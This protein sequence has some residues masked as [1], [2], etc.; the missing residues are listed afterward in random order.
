VAQM[1]AKAKGLAATAV[2]AFFMTGCGGGGGGDAAV[3]GVPSSA[4][5]AGP[6][7]SAT[8]TTGAPT[9][10]ATSNSPLPSAATF[11]Q[12]LVGGPISG[13]AGPAISRLSDGRS[14]VVWV[15]GADRT[16]IA[17]L[18]D[19]AGGLSGPTF[20][21]PI[22][23]PIGST[24]RGVMAA[25]AV[26]GGFVLARE[27][28]DPTPCCA[29]S[30]TG[31]TGRIVFERYASDGT[32]L[33][34]REVANRTSLRIGSLQMNSDGTYTLGYRFSL[35]GLSPIQGFAARLTADGVNLYG[36]TA[37]PTFGLGVEAI[38]AAGL[39]DGSVGVV[40][41]QT[42]GSSYGSTVI[43]AHQVV[44][45]RLDPSG[46][47]IGT[48]LALSPPGSAKQVAATALPNDQIA[49]AWGSDDTTTG[50]GHS[51]AAVIT[52]D[53][54]VAGPVTTMDSAAP[55][56]GVSVALGSNG[57]IVAT[58]TSTVH[59]RGTNSAITTRRFNLSG[60]PQQDSV[61]L[62][63]RATA[64][65][66]PTTGNSVTSAPGFALSGGAD[67]HFVTSYGGADETANVYASGR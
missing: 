45:Q 67:G 12:V 59:S 28:M 22:T 18:L 4:A 53:G 54:A 48:P 17:Q 25:P 56:N 7:V 66:S 41:S 40:W 43:Q 26:D 24:L 47:A 21:L 1:T 63:D 50:G 20:A 42:S 51:Y 6:A 14:V 46:Q 37:L 10:P 65:I 27:A 49:L 35:T 39:S 19:S 9:N 8:P 58:Q 61:L 34:L 33:S 55:V 36:N 29:G 60:S 13:T 11:D 30:P 5:G 64:W 15:D 57:F 38:S 52:R 16:A 31:T 62:V 44:Y 32:L 3:A 23:T 2:V